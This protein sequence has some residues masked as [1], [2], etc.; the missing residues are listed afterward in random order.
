[1]FCSRILAHLAD[2][3]TSLNVSVYIILL[4]IL[5]VCFFLGMFLEGIAIMTLRLPIIFP[6]VT[7]LGFDGIWFGVILIGMINIGLLFRL[8]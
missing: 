3:A 6:I 8:V 1:M 4:L 2:F 5:L 7:S